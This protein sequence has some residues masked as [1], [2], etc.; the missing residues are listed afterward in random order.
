M[1]RNSHDQKY[2]NKIFRHVLSRKTAYYHR[3]LIVRDQPTNF[4]IIK[5]SKRQDVLEVAGGYTALPDNVCYL[6]KNIKTF[7]TIAFK[8][9]VDIVLLNI[10]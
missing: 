10:N 1:F 5:I 3:N 9:N 6:V 4:K 8:S 7:S 2:L